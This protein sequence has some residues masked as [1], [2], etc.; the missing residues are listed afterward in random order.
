MARLSERDRRILLGDNYEALERQF[1]EESKGVLTPQEKRDRW[2]RKLDNNLAHKIDAVVAFVAGLAMAW[3]NHKAGQ[4]PE[5]SVWIGLAVAVL[6]VVW[7]AWLLRDAKRL[8]GLLAGD[9]APAEAV[10]R[11]PQA[12]Q[13]VATAV[14]GLLGGRPASVPH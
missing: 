6:S 5:L 14:Q 13:G 8:R 4:A 7:F 1:L 11:A 12:T 3:G 9:E 2:A 10:R